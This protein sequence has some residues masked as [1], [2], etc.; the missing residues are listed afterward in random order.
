MAPSIVLADGR[1][2]LVVG[3]AGSA[4]LRAAILQVVVNALARGLGVRAAVDAGRL[5]WEGGLIHAE[6]G[7]DTRGLE[8]E[9]V[10]QWKA[11]NLFFGGA[12]AV[13]VRPDGSLAGAG[14]PRRGGAAVVV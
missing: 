12:N 10:V 9:E 3:S 5:H 14:D 4:R 6:A 7:A 13:E 11:Q 2:R 8:G 1:P